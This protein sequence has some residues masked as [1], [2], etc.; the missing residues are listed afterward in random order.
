MKVKRFTKAIDLL[1][2]SEKPCVNIQLPA[3]YR[4]QSAIMRYWLSNPGNG[5]DPDW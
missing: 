5:S 2:F 4:L 1:L 3:F